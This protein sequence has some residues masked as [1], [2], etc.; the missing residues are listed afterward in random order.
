[1]LRSTAF[2]SC[3]CVVLGGCGPRNNND[4]IVSKFLDDISASTTNYY[5]AL[6]QTYGSDECRYSANLS[7][8][9]WKRL[10]GDMRVVETRVIAIDSNSHL[11]DK[12]IPLRERYELAEQEI[13]LAEVEP[14]TA[15]DGTVTYCMQPIAAAQ[16]SELLL[17]ELQSV[18]EHADF[19]VSFK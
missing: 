14:S 12:V 16:V 6:I 17:R 2:I 19:K 5:T 1:M 9:F 13:K 8:K 4:I 3:F 10:Q 15:P 7:K 11:R 18:K